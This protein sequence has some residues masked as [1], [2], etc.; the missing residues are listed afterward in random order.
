VPFDVEQ[1]LPRARHR[2][3][4]SQ[5]L[6]V[7]ALTLRARE[8]GAILGQTLSKRRFAHAERVQSRRVNGIYRYKVGVPDTQVIQIGGEL[9]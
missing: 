7:P 3:Q 9:H 2:L 6:G 8:A 4:V 1:R 5:R